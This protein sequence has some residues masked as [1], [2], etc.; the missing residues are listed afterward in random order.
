MVFTPEGLRHLVAEVGASQIGWG[1][2][3]PFP[4]TKTAVDHLL[5]TPGLSEAERIVI[6]G[7][8]AAKLLALEPTEITTHPLRRPS[9]SL[10][11]LTS[12]RESA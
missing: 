3:H 12:R 7:E 5:T 1:T 4:W 6:R 8:T 2:D 10:L 9:R 11:Q